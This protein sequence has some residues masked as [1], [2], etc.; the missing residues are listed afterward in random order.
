MLL[1]QHVYS[2]FSHTRQ[3]AIR[4]NNG[5][6]YVQV[7]INMQNNVNKRGTGIRGV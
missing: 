2:G 6:S 7:L 4:D 1:I 5:N 3:R